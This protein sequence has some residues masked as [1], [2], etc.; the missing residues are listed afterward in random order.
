MLPGPQTIVSKPNLSKTPASV[1][2]LTLSIEFDSNLLRTK[3]IIFF[4]GSVLSGGK[5]FV[6]LKLIKHLLFFFSF[7]FLNYLKNFQ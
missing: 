2:K 4:S 7:V 1:P 3:L 6:C 5:S